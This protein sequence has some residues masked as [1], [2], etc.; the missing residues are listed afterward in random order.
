[1]TYHIAHM[2]CRYKIRHIPDKDL[3]NVKIWS[4]GKLIADSGD[5]RDEDSL[6]GGRLG[7]YCDSQ[8]MILWSNMIYR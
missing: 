1:M 6:K 8:G 7:V 3:I 5:I 2:I 4:R